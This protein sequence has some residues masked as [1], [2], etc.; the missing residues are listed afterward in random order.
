MINWQPGM[1]LKDLEKLVILHALK[2]YE[3]DKAVTASSLGIARRTL[4]YKIEEYEGKK[5]GTEV[6][7]EENPEVVQDSASRIHVEPSKQAAQKS[8]MPMRKR[9]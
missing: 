1:K 5:S 4:D 9:G 2:F 7:R 6:E 8:P 3:N